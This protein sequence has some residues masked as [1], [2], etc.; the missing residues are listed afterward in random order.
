M[1]VGGVGANMSALEY[2]YKFHSEEV[3][4]TINQKGD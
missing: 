1:A 3:K 4:N 2:I